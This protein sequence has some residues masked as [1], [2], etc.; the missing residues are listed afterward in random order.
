[1]CASRLSENPKAESV[2]VG[3]AKP[4]PTLPDNPKLLPERNELLVANVV[5][6]KWIELQGGRHESFQ[7]FECLNAKIGLTSSKRIRQWRH[8]FAAALQ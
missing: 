8:G 7:N 4:S 1:M 5:R 2:K 6:G 3:S